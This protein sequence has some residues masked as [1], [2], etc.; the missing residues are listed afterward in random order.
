MMKEFEV[1]N[2]KRALEQIELKMV[3][4]GRIIISSSQIGIR[5]FKAYADLE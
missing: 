4:T 3:F 5:L 1:H 2:I